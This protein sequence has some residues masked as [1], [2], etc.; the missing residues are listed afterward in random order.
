MLV[1]PKAHLVFAVRGPHPRPLDRHPAATE[2][3]LTSLVAV[4][5]CRA[6]RVV[7]TL[8]ADHLVDLVIHQFGQDAKPDPDTQ[9]EQALPRRPDQLPERL[10]HTLRQHALTPGRLRD[11]YV[12]LHGGSSFDL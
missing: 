4:T 3:D 9:R 6:L 11:R 2:R 1:G 12:A 5:D 8:G 7:A 10:L